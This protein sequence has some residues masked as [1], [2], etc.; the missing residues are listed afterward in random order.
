MNKQTNRQLPSTAWKP[1]QSGNT[2]GRLPG[3]HQK[4]T[5]K[6]IADI[7]EVWEACGIEVLKRLAVEEPAEL[8]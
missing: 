3:A 2:A 4:I 8:A 6:L 7:A 1:G 5:E